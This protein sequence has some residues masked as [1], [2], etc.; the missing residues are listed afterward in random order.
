MVDEK[1]HW[2]FSAGPHNDL[3][4]KTASH[5]HPTPLYSIF[6]S[7]R[8]IWRV[9]YVLLGQTLRFMN[10]AAAAVAASERYICRRRQIGVD[11]VDA[12]R[13]QILIKEAVLISRKLV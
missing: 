10:W 8:A 5:R 6:K 4:I 7:H 11:K 1:R 13:A 9:Y 2:I 12:K 3:L